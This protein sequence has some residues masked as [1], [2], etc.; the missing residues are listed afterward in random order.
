M[1]DVTN[2]GLKVI[3]RSREHRKFLPKGE[4]AELRRLLGYAAR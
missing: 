1:T 3:G 4:K 2:P